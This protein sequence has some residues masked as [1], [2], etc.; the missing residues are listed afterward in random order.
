MPRYILHIGPHKTGTSYLQTRLLDSAAGLGRAGFYLA[1][2]WNN[3]QFNPSHTGLVERLNSERV[4]ELKPVFEEW[5]NSACKAVIISCEELAGMSR[6]PV[7]VQMLRELTFGCPVTIVYYVRRWPRRLSSEWQE[8][9]K[10]GSTLSLPEVLVHNLRNPPLSHIINIDVCLA[11]YAQIF[12]RSAIRL[13]SYDGVL[14]EGSDIFAHFACHFLDGYEPA[15]RPG[16]VVN[17]SLPPANAELMRLFNCLEQQT[18]RPSRCL[19]PYLQLQHPPAAILRLLDHMGQS[20]ATLDVHDDDGG[21][22]DVLLANRKDYDGCVLPPAG[23]DRFY[24]PQSD[25]LAFI[26]PDYALAPGF[27]DALRRTWH[28]LL[29]LE[30]GKAG[31]RQ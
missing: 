9:I 8:Y 11:A 13:V 18:G 24:E 1:T 23:V 28:E 3:S 12:G 5:R 21:A 14:A 17:E 16:R 10:Q 31:S 29:A 6:E 7:K 30:G 26:R 20:A 25:K 4:S 2:L 15:G 22:G 19:L 27:T